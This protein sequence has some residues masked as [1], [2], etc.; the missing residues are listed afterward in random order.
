MHRLTVAEREGRWTATSSPVQASLNHDAM[1]NYGA[2]EQAC[3]LIGCRKDKDGEYKAQIVAGQTETQPPR[4]LHTCRKP[5]NRYKEVEDSALKRESSSVEGPPSLAR[6]HI[7]S[8]N[9]SSEA[10]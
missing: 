6:R 1:M 7:E 4:L 3:L 8:I 9:E 5:L 10:G 2:M